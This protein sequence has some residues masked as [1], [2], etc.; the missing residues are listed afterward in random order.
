MTAYLLSYYYSFW[1]SF[2]TR[3]FIVIKIK[4]VTKVTNPAPDLINFFKNLPYTDFVI[5]GAGFATFATSSLSLFIEY[6]LYSLPTLKI[7]I[8]II[9][10]II[11]KSS[12]YF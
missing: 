4:Q 11:S 3:V 1:F 2:S 12:I 5:F 7:I 8:I 9:I 6:I 10:I